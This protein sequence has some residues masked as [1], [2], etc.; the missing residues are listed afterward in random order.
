MS[1]WR[2][3]VR[4]RWIEKLCGKQ[5]YRCCWC[6]AAIA[7]P[8]YVRRAGGVVVASSDR[9]FHFRAGEESVFSCRRATVEHLVPVS[10]GGHRYAPSNLAAACWDCNNGRNRVEQCV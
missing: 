7:T 9:E 3:K 1:K 10:R 5:G 6:G 8:E 2:S 4:K